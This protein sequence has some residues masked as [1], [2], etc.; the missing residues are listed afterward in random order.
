MSG[1]KVAIDFCLDRPNE[2]QFLS[3]LSNRTFF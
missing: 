2:P 3:K 1:A